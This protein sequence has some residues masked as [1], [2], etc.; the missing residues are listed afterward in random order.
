MTLYRNWPHVCNL[1]DPLL[2]LLVATT[3]D[4]NTLELLQRAFPNL[5]SEG[6]RFNRVPASAI[7]Q[8][9]KKYLEEQGDDPEDVECH[10]QHRWDEVVRDF[11][12]PVLLETNDGN[13]PMSVAR[14][15]VGLEDRAGH[16]VMWYSRECMVVGIGATFD[17]ANGNI[18]PNPKAVDWVTLVP[19]YCI[20]LNA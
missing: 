7:R 10:V 5:F 4:P 2:R 16:I 20:D 18:I 6:P 13:C 3:E 14:Q 12:I 11:H 1:A 9:L 17:R 15:L 19:A 8:K